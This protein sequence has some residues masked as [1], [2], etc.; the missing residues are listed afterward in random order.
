MNQSRCKKIWTLRSTKLLQKLKIHLICYIPTSSKNR[1]LCYFY[2]KAI[3]FLIIKSEHPTFYVLLQFT[4][5]RTAFLKIKKWRSWISRLK[6]HRDDQYPTSQ[7]CETMMDL[8]FRLKEKLILK[9]K[10]IDHEEVLRWKDR[11]GCPL[12][13]YNNRNRVV[14]SHLEKAGTLH[15]S[16]PKSCQTPSVAVSHTTAV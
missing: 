11:R 12:T 2:S 4:E 8:K 7:I 14:Y 15:W 5:Q 3:Q 1:H 13:I 10:A 16:F 6:T 9:H